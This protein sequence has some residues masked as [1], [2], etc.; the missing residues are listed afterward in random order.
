[1]AS[2]KKKI[3]NKE[4]LTTWGWIILILLSL[5]ML[6]TPF[7]FGFFNGVGLHKTGQYNFEKHLLYGLMM[8]VPALLFAA[9][10]M[11]RKG[12]FEHR[13][14]MGIAGA[15]IPLVYLLSSNNAKTPYL[16]MIDINFNVLLYSF[17]L[18]GIF[19]SDQRKILQYASN[20]FLTFGYIMVICGFTFLF[21]NIYKIDALLFSDG[22]RLASFFTYPN[23]Y[24][25]FLLT[26]LLG[27][28]HHLIKAEKRIEVA[29]H[30]FMLVPIAASLLLT[31]SRGAIIMLPV[32]ALVT[33]ILFN[34]RRQLMMMIYICVSV[35]FSVFITS[36]LSARGTQVYE[37]IQQ[38]LAV[39][40]A[41]VSQSFFSSASIGGWIRI[42]A[43]SLVMSG[44]VYLIHRYVQASLNRISLNWIQRRGSKF[45]IPAIITVIGIAVIMVLSSGIVPTDKLGRL[46]NIN[47]QTHS[48]LERFEFYKNAF[49]MWKDNPLIGGGGGAWEAL[50]DQYQSY[51]YVSAQTH[52]YPIQILIETG[53]IGLIVF[54]LFILY[55]VVMYLIGYYKNQESENEPHTLF[56]LIAISLLLHSLIDFEMSYGFFSA[57]VFLCLGIMCGNL[58]ATLLSSR[59]IRF[60]ERIKRGT[61]ALWL[62]I[63]ILLTVSLSKMWYTNNQYME[64]VKRAQEEKPLEAILQPL[65]DGLE[66]MPGHPFLLERM[67]NYQLRAY[68]QTK[69]VQYVQAAQM[70]YD[71]MSRAEPYFRNLSN[72]L[73]SL[74]LQQGDKAQGVAVLEDAISQYPYELSFYDQV[75][76]DRYE[77]WKAALASSDTQKRIDQEEHIMKW[78]EEVNRRVDE[79]KELPK[80]IVYIRP[81]EVTTQM[82]LITGQ[83]YYTQQNYVEASQMMKEGL[84]ETITSEEDKI[85]SRLYIAS[86]RKQG[87]D[88][89]PLYQQ[90]IE[91][92]PNEEEEINKLLKE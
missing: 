32:I 91:S 57:L 86:L 65:L 89:L 52:S 54:V 77:L 31:V 20:L 24:A 2:I 60:S 26:I 79:L 35:L 22:V 16:S 74:A 25:A 84:K 40:Q 72:G 92:D 17:F 81:F 63:A 69:D 6:I 1:M 70:Y 61:A 39:G 82:R 43:V 51:P 88:D 90:L 56:F 85:L 76:A 53:I 48:V 4:P 44:I 21:G 27:N 47:F 50:Y 5:F 58:R 37:S 28:L 42:L 18:M 80:A 38:Q 55:I 71:K 23:A 12:K 73:Y 83:I 78:N 34:V 75:I 49:E 19:I 67:A 10:S 33:L 3:I 30:G 13:H 36:D 8:G 46:G 59:S 87:Q 62:I 29:I 45:V 41:V 15:A 66:R 9:F 68:E 14:L 11:I 64:S 7:Q